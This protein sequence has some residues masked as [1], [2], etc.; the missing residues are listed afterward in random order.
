MEKAQIGRPREFDAEEALQKAMVVFWEQGY[1]GA[2]L[3]DLTERMGISRKSMYAAFG[4]KEELF[5]KALQRYS[6][7]TV[8]YAVEALQA[9]TAREVA[10]TFL[11]GSVRA[12]T[13]PGC[14]A[15]CLGVQGAL[16]VGETGRVARDILTEWRNGGQGLLRDRFERAVEEGD[17]PGDA[18]PDLIA[19]Y[20]MTIGNGMAVQA[21]GGAAREDLQ[22]VADAALRNWPPA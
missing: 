9:A 18:D 7:G 15:G 1:E 2:S 19:R 3:T 20:V 6:E 10:E 16:A 8:S 5:R 21:A 14:P 12:N 4:N 13:R 11:A 17:L 22:R